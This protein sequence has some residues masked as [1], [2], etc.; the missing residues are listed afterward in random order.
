MN[1]GELDRNGRCGV[2]EGVEQIPLRRIPDSRG[3]IVHFMR[4]TDEAFQDFDVQEVYFSWVYSGAIKA[5]HRH[6]EM[7]L[8]YAVLVGDIKLVLFDSR[9][10]SPSYGELEEIYL[11]EHSPHGIIRV[12]P[13]IWNGFM[14]VGNANALVANVTDVVHRPDEIQRMTLYEFQRDHYEYDWHESFIG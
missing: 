1:Y 5:W 9:I 4:K 11:G 14:A 13:M 6:T 2:I 3:R 7:T 8:N 10:D 12:P